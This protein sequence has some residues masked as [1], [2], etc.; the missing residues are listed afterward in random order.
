M[1]AYATS[2]DLAARWKPIDDTNRAETLLG[3]AAVWLR[4]WFPDLDL[5][6]ASGQ[7]D[8]AIPIMVSCAMVKR[9]ML[10]TD[11]DG[12]ASV[13]RSDSAGVYSHS[14]N[15]SFSN[16]EGNL[17]LTSR[18]ESLLAGKPVEAVSYTATGLLG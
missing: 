15:R 1:A 7:L 11:T 3:D 13:Q 17:Y 16:P 12:A 10:N 5:R 2:S 18:E 9:A 6:I 4:T 14:E 8:P